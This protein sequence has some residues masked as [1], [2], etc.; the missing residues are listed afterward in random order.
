MTKMTPLN[1]ENSETTEQ[2][3][4]ELFCNCSKNKCLKDETCNKILHQN[5]TSSEIIQADDDIDS[6]LEKKEIFKIAKDPFG[7][8]NL[9]D[10]A[11]DMLGIFLIFVITSIWCI[12]AIIWLRRLKRYKKNVHD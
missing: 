7:L 2:S 11:H 1:S 5:I 6:T 4:C 8:R 9:K 10:A 12:Y 3:R